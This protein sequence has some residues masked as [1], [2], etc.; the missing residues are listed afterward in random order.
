MMRRRIL[1]AAAAVSLMMTIPGYASGIED[2]LT[3]GAG[4][5]TQNQTPSE[6]WTDTGSGTELPPAPAAAAQSLEIVT[7]TD[8]QTGLNVG[9]A[10]VPEGYTVTNE[11]TWC[12]P[13]QSP[14]Y[15]ACVFVSA[16]SPDGGI[17]LTYESPLSFT[18]QLS[19]YVNGID[20]TYHQDWGFDTDL[21]MTMLTYRTAPQYCDFVS[22]YTMDGA[23]NMT[24][25]SEEPQSEELK[26][27][28]AQS[29]Q[30]MKDT[31]NQFYASVQGMSV[32]YVE[33][34]AAQRTYTYTDSATGK[35]KYLIVATATQGMRIVG[36]FSG[37][38]MGEV[39]IVYV[40]WT[41]PA[42]YSLIC[43]AD[44]L[45]EG[46]AVFEAFCSNTTI[47]DQFKQAMNNLGQQ[48]TMTVLAARNGGSTPSLASQTSDIQDAF[49]SELSGR[50]DTYSSAEAWDDVIMERNDYTLSNGDNVKVD[51]SYDYVY[52]LSDG[53]V[54]ATD[55]ALDEPAGATLLYAN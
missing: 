45:E 48:I 34:T 44:K 2:F 53:N 27:Q 55:S 54:Y 23:V 33:T 24:F 28:L 18:Q 22:Q 16:L 17:Q 39:K 36:D 51:I 26:A 15:P 50:D 41:V 21:M 7:C 31:A 25:V 13:C 29:S 11:T 40:V 9:R 42:R 52:E 43:D 14:G 20:L 35:Q 12:G 46:R 10:V 38:G 8:S 4:G 37:L 49:S 32:D 3:G 1:A 47:S 5:Q 6:G 19:S 30:Q